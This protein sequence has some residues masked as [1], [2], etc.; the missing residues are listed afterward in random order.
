MTCLPMDDIL[1]AESDLRHLCTLIDVL[2]DMAINAVG[3]LSPGASPSDKATL[4][5][6]G[7]MLWIARDLSNQTTQRLENATARLV[8]ERA[9]QRMTG[10][11]RN[12]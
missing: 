4:N 9:A 1:D 12:G 3:S 7:D 6:I 2:T 11:D 10:G 5:A 8:T